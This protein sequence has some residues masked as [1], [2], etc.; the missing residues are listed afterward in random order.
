MCSSD[1]HSRALWMMD[2]DALFNRAP[3]ALFELLG[4]NDAAFRVRAGRMEPW[5]QFS[6]GIVGARATPA[7]LQ[8]FRGI[9][10]YIAHFKSEGQLNWGI[11]QAAMYSVFV[12]LQ[13]QGRAPTLTFLNDLAMDIEYREQGILWCSAGAKKFAMMDPK[14]VPDESHPT[15]RYHARYKRY[16]WPG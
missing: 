4:S 8:Y 5:N 15:G 13:A 6:A 10:A 16:R 9:A 11:D 1:L 7:A 12:Y 2:V 14:A 3:S